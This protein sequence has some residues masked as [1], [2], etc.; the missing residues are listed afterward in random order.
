MNSSKMSDWVVY[1]DCVTIDVE[2]DEQFH[3]PHPLWPGLGFLIAFIIGGILGA[4]LAKFCLKDYLKKR[5]SQYFI[6]FIA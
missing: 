6:T 2:V 5:V 4:I 3:V 1:P